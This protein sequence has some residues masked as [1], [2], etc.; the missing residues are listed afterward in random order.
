MDTDSRLLPFVQAADEVEADRL[1]GDLLTQLADP[2]IKA[3]VAS[4]LRRSG[5]SS[6]GNRSG[7]VAAEIDDLAGDARLQILIRL[8]KLRLSPQN[9]IIADFGRYVAATAYN[10][11]HS[12]SRRQHPWRSRLKDRLR[13]ILSHHPSMEI[14]ADQ[15]SGLVCGPGAWREE[16]KQPVSD[17]WIKEFRSEAV[18]ALR[19]TATFEPLENYQHSTRLLASIFARAAA[20]VLLDDLA[21]IMADIWRIADRPPQT[22]TDCEDEI[23]DRFAQTKMDPAA[24]IERRRYVERL[25]LEI[26]QLPV[27]HRVALLLHLKDTTGRSILP[28]L[29][30][31]RIATVRTMGEVLGMS[32][33]AFATLWE[34]LPL[35]D[36]S[37]A[38]YL[39]VT[40][41]QVASFRLSARRR[42]VRRA[43]AFEA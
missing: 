2:L 7:Q 18:P 21:T 38:N 39:E 42:L 33:E 25:W 43:K 34:Q 9:G 28:L 24:M 27:P 1:L 14:W 3:V 10:T 40:R 32:P 30:D 20:P 13:Y 37:I 29:A 11:C 12:H 17:S 22:L 19:Q 26:T 35:D 6:Q 5:L 16:G 41:Q 23:V 8:R 36:L 15:E 4:A 31:M